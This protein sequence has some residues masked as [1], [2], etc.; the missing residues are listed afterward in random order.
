MFYSGNVVV[1]GLLVVLVVVGLVCAL[2]A[3]AWLL[4]VRARRSGIA[5][6]SRRLGASGPPLVSEPSLMSG[7]SLIPEAPLL[8]E[9]SLID[10][11]TEWLDRQ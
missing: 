3:W 1:A 11:I 8:D 6:I 10:E 5:E 2:V 4:E 9:A 7:P